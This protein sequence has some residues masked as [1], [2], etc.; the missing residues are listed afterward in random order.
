MDGRWAYALLML[1][2]TPRATETHQTADL[3]GLR[4]L[5]LYWYW[6]G[7]GHTRSIRAAGEEEARAAIL[8]QS[9][10]ARGQRLT[11]ERFRLA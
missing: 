4:A 5:P 8:A 3:F 10:H 9:P 11:V 7:H 2:E 6:I 1:P